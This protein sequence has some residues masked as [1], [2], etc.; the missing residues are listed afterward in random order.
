MK[1]YQKYRQIIDEIRPVQ[2]AWFTTFNL[3]PELVEKYLVSYIAGKEAS[4]LK[5]AEDYEA[6]N[7]ELSETDIKVWYDFRALN[8][9]SPKRTCID[10]IPVNPSDK[11]RNRGKDALFHPKVIFLKGE[12]GAYLIAGSAN[13]SF[14]AWSSNRESVLIKKID[15]LKNGKQVLDFF[16][17][18]GT[19]NNKLERWINSLP[20]TISDW[21]F[22]HS[23]KRDFNLFNFITKGDLTVWAPYFS[24][25]AVS[26]LNQI[27]KLGYSSITLVPNI[28]QHGKISIK[29]EEVEI[30]TAIQ[31]V[32]IKR[33]NKIDESQNLH[34]A[35]V[36]LTQ[37]TLAI[38]SWNCSHRATGL[39]IS[40]TD[41]NIEAGIIINIEGTETY[42][43]L[44]NMIS[45]FESRE[46]IQ[47]QTEEELDAEWNGVLNDFT[48]SVEISANWENFTYGIEFCDEKVQNNYYAKLPH[49]P[50]EKVPLKNVQG[51]SFR[52][53]HLKVLKNKNFSILDVEGKT[54]FNGYIREIGKEKRPVYS[55]VNLSDL[56]ES[57]INDP[58][59]STEAKQC[60]YQLSVEENGQ[61]AETVQFDYEGAESFY[62]MFTSFQ[63]LYDKIDDLKGKPS[64]LDKLGFRLPGSLLNIRELVVEYIEKVL[65]VN[66]TDDLIYGYFLLLETNRC[67]TLFNENSDAK[68]PL[69][70]LDDIK[71][72][73]RFRKNDIKFLKGLKNEFGYELI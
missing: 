46:K 48:V 36:W 9:I 26:L 19:K 25:K 60:R 23:Y 73:L 30:L 6:L 33:P 1:L 67:I 14:S 18:L 38:G 12:K 37:G 29:E 56:F 71:G 15:N 7:T 62:V 66:N 61:S 17:P 10:F 22:V 11:F 52:E 70:H 16:K 34:H 44:R 63:K 57:L 51:L 45:D 54:V 50:Q 53:N 4:E 49:N 39:N 42:S 40:S 28:N 41:K 64:E 59:K 47:G 2:V 55:Y 68:I 31:N 69:L 43:S 13:L 35:K 5:T 24:K 65:D 8:L 3:D 20:E 32:F 72:K 21:D 58:T 27:M